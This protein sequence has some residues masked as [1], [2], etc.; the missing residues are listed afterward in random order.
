GL[1]FYS[2]G[3]L[4]LA[5]LSAEVTSLQLFAALCAPIGHELLIQKENEREMKEEPI[6]IHPDRGV[7][8]LATVADSPAQKAGLKSGDVI[9][10][11]NNVYIGNAMDMDDA[12]HVM[13][14]NREIEYLRG[15][16]LYRT[17]LSGEQ[18]DP[19]GLILVPH[20]N[21]TRYAHLEAEGVAVMDWLKKRGGKKE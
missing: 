3:L 8:L 4:A 1:A 7:R 2:I 20:G 14:A 6:F 10:R 17:H 11:L 9:T 15:N 5:L 13:V 19:Y 12:A 21:E 18:G 16:K